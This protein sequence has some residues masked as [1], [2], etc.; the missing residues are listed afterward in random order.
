MDAFVP[1]E[2]GSYVTVMMDGISWDLPADEERG[3]HCVSVSFR[4]S[5][6][7]ATDHAQHVPDGGPRT[8]E[9][10][11]RAEIPRQFG[12]AVNWGRRASRNAVVASKEAALLPLVGIDTVCVWEEWF[13]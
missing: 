9:G 5:K 10:S 11:F 12:E 13:G 2:G 6:Q 7:T 4:Q 3:L 1:R 8:L